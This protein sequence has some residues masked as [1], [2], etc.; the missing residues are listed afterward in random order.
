LG[1][2]GFSQLCAGGHQNLTITSVQSEWTNIIGGSISSNAVWHTRFDTVDLQ[3]DAISLKIVGAAVFK[4]FRRTPIDTPAPS[5]REVSPSPHPADRRKRRVI[6]AVRQSP[7]WHAFAFPQSGNCWAERDRG[8]LN[9][10]NR[11]RSSPTRKLVKRRTEPSYR[12]FWKV[13]ASVPQVNGLEVIIKTHLRPWSS[14]LAL[15]LDPISCI[16]FGET[17]HDGLHFALS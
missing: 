14:P 10:K 15:L 8:Q 11:C 16:T 7:Q 12:S 9:R 17:V 3:C 6:T 4:D 5:Q 1:V 2:R 13:L